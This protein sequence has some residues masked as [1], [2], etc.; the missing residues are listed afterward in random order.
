MKN[1]LCYISL[2][3]FV[4]SCN[5]LNGDSASKDVFEAGPILFTYENQL[6]SMEQ[7][8]SDVKQL[9]NDSDFPIFDAR[10]SPDG[11]KIAIIALANPSDNNEF[12]RAIYIMKS[13]GSGMRRLTNPPLGL[14]RYV[15]DVERKLTWSPDGNHIA[16]SRM[17]PP[18]VSGNFDI[19]MVE[20]ETGV[21]SLVS[22]K[23]WIEYVDDWHPYKD[24]LLIHY[25]GSDLHDSASG[26]VIGY[27]DLNGEYIEALSD[28]ELSS[29]Q[30]RISPDGSKVA[31]KK[32]RKLY[33]MDLSTGKEQLLFENSDPAPQ[34]WSPCGRKIIFQQWSREIN[35]EERK[36]FMI[37]ID[38]G[39]I[40]NITP[41]ESPGSTIWVSS[42]RN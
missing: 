13:D 12:A 26:G 6:W 31:Y 17:R 10:W 39:T 1:L 40:Q 25:I 3:I 28:P 20:L 22:Q 27:T 14:F 19:F 29:A 23:N 16:F 35:Y 30:G 9:T 2:V 24:K 34:A 21:E 18:E 36:V 42:W 33:L 38:D 41:L 32:D 4:V 37:N 11:K 15:G 8:G 5:I 7:D